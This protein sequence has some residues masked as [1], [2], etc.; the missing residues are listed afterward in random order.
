MSNPNPGTSTQDVPVKVTEDVKEYASKLLVSNANWAQRLNQTFPQYFPNIKERQAPKILWLGCS[1]SRVH[2]SDAIAAFPGTALVHRNVAN[3]FHLNDD[4]ALSDLAYAVKE[5]GIQHIVVVGHEHCGGVVSA[6]K[7]ARRPPSVSGSQTKRRHI[8]QDS[9]YHV[10]EEIFHVHIHKDEPHDSE[11]VSVRES[12]NNAVT[13]WMTPLI[14]RLRGVVLPEDEE[15]ALR[16]A[17]EEN[18][19]MQVETLGGMEEFV[20]TWAKKKPVW[21]HGWVYDTSTGFLRDLEI[22]RV[23]G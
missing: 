12:P 3:Q 10:V 19:R 4:S 16:I 5:L 23:L 7:E 1:D 9:I 15:G 14:D 20:K 13:R 11:E 21:V 2:D 8:I 6:M 17:T 18:V 22:T